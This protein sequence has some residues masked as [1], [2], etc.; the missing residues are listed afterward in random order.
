M[1]NGSG[2]YAIAFSTNPEVR[3]TRPRRAKPSA[4]VDVP[5]DQMSPLFEAAVEATEEAVI[6]S[7]FAAT[8]MDGA[9]GHIDALPVDQ[10]INLYQHQRR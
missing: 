10:V 7:L 9:H 5:N 4:I 6:N 1:T 8:P 2:D 3:R